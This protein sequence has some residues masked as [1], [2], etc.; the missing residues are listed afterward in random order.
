M[1]RFSFVILALAAGL[2]A[3]PVLAQTS[4][5]PLA[6][7]AVI[8]RPVPVE[9][10]PTRS[11]RIVDYPSR[12]SPYAIEPLY[13]V[14]SKIIV[15]GI[16]GG[17]YPQDIKSVMV[18]KGDD[19]PASWRLTPN[20]GVIDL[21]LKKSVRMPS[22]SLASLKRQAHLTGPVRFAVD[23][24]PLPDA[25]LRVATRGIERLEAQSAR[26]DGSPA[27]LNILLTRSSPI[28]HPPGKTRRIMLRGPARR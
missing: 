11:F 28:N 15:N 7:A 1:Q 16:L 27:E 18:Y 22:R 25:T 6:P 13:L 14:N 4:V 24:R 26:P 17:I 9:V 12:T 21:H 2:P 8:V 23:G 3:R 5:S 10:P 19:T 20:G